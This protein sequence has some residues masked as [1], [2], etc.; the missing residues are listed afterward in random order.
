MN[1]TFPPIYLGIETPGST[2]APSDPW[3][4]RGGIA[5]IGVGRSRAHTRT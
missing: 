4:E 2:A 3:N 1:D 5:I